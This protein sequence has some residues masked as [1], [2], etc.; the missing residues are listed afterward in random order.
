[1]ITVKQRSSST[2]LIIKKLGYMDSNNLFFKSSIDNCEL[3]SFHYKKVLKEV[4]PIA[5]YCVDNRPFVLFFEDSGSKEEISAI[6]TKVWNAQIPVVIF[7]NDIEIKIYNGN[8]IGDKNELQYLET[9]SVDNCDENSSFSYWNVTK[10]EFWTDLS[11]RYSSKNLNES[12]LENIEFVT[13]K[14]KNEFN[15]QSATKLILRLIF[16]RFLIDRGVDIGFDGLS[17]DKNISKS[18]FLKIIADK[19]QLYKLFAYLKDKFNGNLFDLE[20]EDDGLKLPDASFPMLEDFMSGGLVLKSGQYSLFPL[21]DF[22][23]IPVE[24]ISNIYEVL[25][26]KE[27]Q[28]SDKAFYTPNY[29]VDYI[30]SETVDVYLETNQTCKILDPACGSGIFLVETFRR[31]IDKNCSSRDSSIDD[32]KLK[33]LLKENIFG[34]D[35]NQDAIDVAIFSLYLT[36]L[37]YIDPKSLIEFKLPNLLG[38]NLIVADF[39]D[40]NNT[41]QL[42]VNEYDFILGNP[43][44]GSVTGEFLREFRKTKK[45]PQQNNEISRD[46]I[47]MA[48]EYCSST[49][50]CCFVLP[51]KI[52]YNSQKPA[53][54]FRKLMLERFRIETV[55]ELSSVRKM[56]FKNADAPAAIVAF[57]IEENSTNSFKHIS[58]KPNVFFKLFNIIVREKNDTKFVKQKLLLDY[59]WAWKTL[60]FGSVYDFEIIK[61][62]KKKFGT[63][64]KL[65]NDGILCSDTG[66]S[67]NNGDLNPSEHLINQPYFNKNDDIDHFYIHN[68]DNL[69]LFKKDKIHR[70]KPLDCFI[71]PYCLIRK[72]VDCSNYKMRAAYTEHKFVYNSGIAAIK[73][74]MENKNILLNVT[75]LLNSSFYAYLNLMLASSI[76]VER[77]QRFLVEIQKYPYVYDDRIVQKVTEI[78]ESYS[79]SNSSDCYDENSELRRLDKIVLD[80]FG[81]SDDPF[82][83]YALNIQIPELTN[84][85]KKTKINSVSEKELETYASVFQN[86]WSNKLGKASR[87]IKINLYPNIKNKFTVFEMIFLDAGNDADDENV[88][89]FFKNADYI[90]ELFSHFMINKI[91]DM[92]YEFKDVINFENNSFFIIKT[93]EAKNWHPAMAHIDLADVV[94]SILCGSEVE[95]K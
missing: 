79:N 69:P 51:S 30:L 12:M 75:G 9:V 49:T 55:I 46:F 67:A 7:N 2:N 26:G 83:D 24:L 13:E 44:W 25:L 16:I 22:N 94:D 15:I 61:S 52:L 64:L 65:I 38:E 80:T 1:M 56:V 53:I 11:N 59:D 77:E 63:I 18:N 39:F 17:S 48:C 47:I 81:L 35:K 93:N 91:N 8:A 66:I 88:I 60:L 14:L 82:I 40:E 74:N 27:A 41:K 32:E 31:L 29:L 95:Y 10:S 58:L 68:L 34:I 43:P 84:L 71:P 76:G 5:F 62:L 85:N 78:M 87:A 70:P 73:G 42:K 86:Y 90:K 33:I 45:Y 50:V 19:H 23:I 92:F 36:V 6:F 3:L 21:Y 54:A 72:G 37:D 4:N 20:D 89:E 57:R 28:E